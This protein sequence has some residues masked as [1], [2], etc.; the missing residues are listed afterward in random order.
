[1]KSANFRYRISAD[2]PPQRAFDD[3]TRVADWWSTRFEGTSRN[4][5]DVFT[6]HFGDTHKT[7]RIVESVPGSRIVW[8][9]IDSNMPWLAD[10][11]EWTGTRI[12]WDVSA[13]GSATEITLTHVGLVPGIE[14]YSACEAGWTYFA[15]ESLRKLMTEGKGL[16][17]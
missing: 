4:P 2:I 17:H 11:Q 8:E 5:G 15:Q 7:F 9:V 10:K 12:V 13:R 16:P 1:M 3:I 14:C 6:V